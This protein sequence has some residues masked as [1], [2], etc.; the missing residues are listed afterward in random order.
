MDRDEIQPAATKSEERP[1][2]ISTE[3]VEAFA[4][5]ILATYQDA[6]FYPLGIPDA[7]Y[8]EH[9]N[10]FI[11][12]EDIVNAVLD[13]VPGNISSQDDL[14]FIVISDLLKKALQY[15]IT[16]DKAS[17][18]STEV[19]IP[20]PCNFT[21]QRPNHLETAGRATDPMFAEYAANLLQDYQ[22]PDISER[23]IIGTLGEMTQAMAAGFGVSPQECLGFLDRDEV[24]AITKSCA[25]AD[26]PDL[27]GLDEL[28]Q[29][30]LM[31]A[32][33][34]GAGSNPNSFHHP[35]SQK[36]GK[37]PAAE[38]PGNDDYSNAP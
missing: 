33:S 26:P 19:P 21:S 29:A 11:E 15:P 8:N 6:D 14:S 27:A 36:S 22:I 37:V 2:A 24:I 7:L 10:V 5:N 32:L 34:G 35:A 31:S 17:T 9:A 4:R 30:L 1:R 25:Q 18:G 28:D 20:A 13:M 16:K 3:I 12:Q 38:D 23:D